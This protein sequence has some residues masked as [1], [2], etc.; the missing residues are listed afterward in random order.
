[1]IA[2]IRGR[3]QSA[4]GALL[5]LGLAAFGRSVGLGF[6]LACEKALVRVLATVEA[7]DADAHADASLSVAGGAVAPHHFHLQLDRAGLF[8][9]ERDLELRTDLAGLF[10]DDEHAAAADVARFGALA[11]TFTPELLVGLEPRVATLVVAH[12]APA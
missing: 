5:A 11:L 9:V 6:A 8:V 12:R 10:A 3:E 4:C 7:D 2:E 1:M